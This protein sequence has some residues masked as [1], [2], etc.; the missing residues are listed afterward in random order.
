MQ[1]KAILTLKEKEANT[2]T[3]LCMKHYVTCFTCWIGIVSHF[4][5]LTS[6]RVPWITSHLIN[7][8]WVKAGIILS[9]KPHRVPFQ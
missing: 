1:Y 5:T 7:V 6:K 2:Y 9:F 8:C 4:C 3:P